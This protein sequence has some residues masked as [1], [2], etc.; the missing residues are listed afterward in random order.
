MGDSLSDVP[1]L[2]RVQ[3]TWFSLANSTEATM[4]RADVSTQHKSGRA[5]CP[6]FEDVGTARFLADRVEV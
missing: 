6:T 4:S 5:V 2:F 3:F 1:W